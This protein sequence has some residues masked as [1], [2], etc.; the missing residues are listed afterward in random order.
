MRV[1]FRRLKLVYK[2]D[3]NS[4]EPVPRRA[5]RFVCNDYSRTSNVCYKNVGWQDT[6]K[7]HRFDHV[8]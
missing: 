5:A 7:D 2:K 4:I 3:N 8:L 6:K 1:R